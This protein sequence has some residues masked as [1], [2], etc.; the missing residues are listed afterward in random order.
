MWT[1][2]QST[3]ILRDPTGMP[4]GRGYAGGD[5]GKAPWGI[6]NPSYESVK[7]EGP[8][9]CGL[10]T[11]GAVIETD[12]KLGNFVIPLVPD[13]DT[14]ASIVAMGRGPFSFYMHGDNIVR[15]GERA[16]SDGCIV[17]GINVRRAFNASLDDQ[18][19]VIAGPTVQTEATT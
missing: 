4:S 19:Q 7:D 5:Q 1:Y 13:E 2:E 17:M 15:A 11:R 6:N 12:P 14:A 9:P 10:F 3:G 16:G 18:L 8:I